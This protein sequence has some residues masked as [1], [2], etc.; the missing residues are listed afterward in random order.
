MEDH[1]NSN[2]EPSVPM[3]VYEE[4]YQ[5][6]E[7]VRH[8]AGTH[9]GTGGGRK[10]YANLDMASMMGVEVEPG[11]DTN[12]ISDTNKKSETIAEKTAKLHKLLGD[13]DKAERSFH[14]D[15]ES[16]ES[17]KLTDSV[18]EKEEKDVCEP[19]H[20][21]PTH[22][23]H[24]HINNDIYALPVKRRPKKNDLLAGWEKHEVL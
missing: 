19:V 21:S 16:P 6:L 4:L 10:V 12:T 9:S 8:I 23:P 2:I 18:S 13:S 22:T 1:L 5:E 11:I 20:Q 24:T 14:L 3:S 17:E 7:G 15:A